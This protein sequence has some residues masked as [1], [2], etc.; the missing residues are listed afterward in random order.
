AYAWLKRLTRAERGSRH[1]IERRQPA[2]DPRAV[3][4]KIPVAEQAARI[5]RERRPVVAD[6]QHRDVDGVGETHD[7]GLLDEPHAAVAGWVTVQGRCIRL[8]ENDTS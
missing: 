5:D 8:G 2:L 4:P 7:P 6:R 1:H 3:H